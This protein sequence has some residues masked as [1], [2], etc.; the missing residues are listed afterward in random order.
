MRKAL[1]IA[2][3][4]GTVVLGVALAKPTPEERILF[5]AVNRERHKVGL[6]ALRWDDALAAA[7]RQH[8]SAMAKHRSV[9]HTLAG[10][11]S[12]PGRATRAGVHFSSL[13]ENIVVAQDS[14]SA[15]EAF[16]HSPNHRANMMDTEMDSI[17]IGM[18]ERGGQVYVVEDFAKGK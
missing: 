2:V 7:A 11:P 13:A 10:E 8:A 12:L 15:H 3:L 4:L 16:L 1:S 9:A 18:V 14:E 17:G 6:S 5:E